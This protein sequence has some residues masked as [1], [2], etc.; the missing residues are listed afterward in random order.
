MMI[1]LLLIPL[2]LAF[3]ASGC[4]SDSAQEAGPLPTAPAASQTIPTETTPATEPTTTTETAP[5]TT[6][7]A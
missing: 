3:L 6:E 5:T 4:G 7:A 2:A 1:R